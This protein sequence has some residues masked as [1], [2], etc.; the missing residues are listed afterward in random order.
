MADELCL[1]NLDTGDFMTLGKRAGS[2]Y[3]HPKDD[4]DGV[5][6][7]GYSGNH[8]LIAELPLIYDEDHEGKHQD[9]VLDIRKRRGHALNA[10][11]AA[12]LGCRLI[13]VRQQFLF[14]IIDDAARE[15]FD[16]PD[17]VGTEM[18]GYLDK[19]EI[20]SKPIDDDGNPIS[21]GTFFYKNRLARSR[22]AE[23][24]KTE[25]ERQRHQEKTDH[26][27]SEI[28]RAL[29]KNIVRK[30]TNTGEYDYVY[31]MGQS[32]AEITIEDENQEAHRKWAQKNLSD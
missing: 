26:Y 3:N 32:P 21:E 19:N 2:G 12:S 10:F 5:P 20:G 24:P 16:L 30:L 11:L 27:E 23:I 31:S 28:K 4:Y 14:A 6:E 17:G 15:H 22:W 1:L 8:S 7:T 25:A 13:V 18:F 9:W 29:A